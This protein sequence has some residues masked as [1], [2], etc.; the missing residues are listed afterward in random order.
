ML[1]ALTL[2]KFFASGKLWQYANLALDSCGAFGPFSKE[3]R[4][5][6]PERQSLKLYFSLF[7]FCTDQNPIRG[8]HLANKNQY[9]PPLYLGLEDVRL[10]LGILKSSLLSLVLLVRRQETAHYCLVSVLKLLKEIHGKVDMTTKTKGKTS[11][12]VGFEYFWQHRH[13]WQREFSL[14][15]LN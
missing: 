14:K 2:S 7:P 5:S 4:G 15:S 11:N 8:S 10:L 13:T 6:S 3:Q 1:D 12:E 9:L